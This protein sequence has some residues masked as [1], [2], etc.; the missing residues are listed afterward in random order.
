VAIWAR[1]SSFTA[2]KE[3]KGT[4]QWSRID[5][6]DVI[7]GAV[8]SNQK[9]YAIYSLGVSLLPFFH[10]T[11]GLL[12]VSFNAS[13]TKEYIASLK[14]FKIFG[15]IAYYVKALGF[16]FR[17]DTLKAGLEVLA[18]EFETSEDPLDLASDCK[19]QSIIQAI[20]NWTPVIKDKKIGREV[21]EKWGEKIIDLLM[22]EYAR[23][24]DS[25]F[26][27][28]IGDANYIELTI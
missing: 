25:G 10:A 5:V 12:K 9:A 2:V 16:K 11:K 26:K 13:E 27:V 17:S 18:Q 6:F 22:V 19:M 3:A 21:A 7:R 24:G 4:M 8:T 14:Q 23:E 20:R 1:G 15:V 28:W